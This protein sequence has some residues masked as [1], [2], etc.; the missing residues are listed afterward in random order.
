MRAYA[1]LLLCFLLVELVTS[2][3]TFIEGPVFKHHRSHK[4]HIVKSS[5]STLRLSCDASGTPTPNITW[6]KDGLSPLPRRLTPIKTYKWTLVLEDMEKEDAGKYTCKVCNE[7]GCKDLQFDVEVNEREQNKPRLVK[8]LHNMT[9]EI[10]DRVQLKCEFDSETKPF[11]MW[12]KTSDSHC[13]FGEKEECDN[14]DMLQKSY[15]GRKNPEVYEIS[16]VRRHD[17]GWYACIGSNTLGATVSKA[18]LKV[19]S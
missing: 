12:M 6:Y 19:T 13:T 10:G 3:I 16:R 1:S 9:V 17:E 5:G 14:V 11:I 7:V 18:Y 15:D 2:E 4:K 8:E